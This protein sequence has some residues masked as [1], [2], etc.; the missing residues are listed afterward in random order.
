MKHTKLLSALFGLLFV[1]LL[2][3][4]AMLGITFRNAEPLVMASMEKADARTEALMEAL[5]QQDYAAAGKLISGK[6]KL[7]PNGEPATALGKVL[8]EAYGKSLSYEF[9]GNS[10]VSDGVVCRQVTVTLL[11]IPALMEELQ[12]KSTKTLAV[13]AAENPAEA[14]DADGAFCEEFVAEALAESAESMV[15][16]DEYMTE[17]SLTLQLT[18]HGGKWVVCADRTLM[19]L[20]VGGMGGV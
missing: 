16:S 6:P 8:W 13:K 14:Y 10:Y 2:V 5:C 7:E 19:D 18:G 9:D 12:A 3:G 17:R 4:T 1:L 15:K 20:F 11:D